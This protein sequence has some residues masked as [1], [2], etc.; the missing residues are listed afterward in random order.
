MDVNW[1]GLPLQQ[2]YCNQLQWSLSKPNSLWINFCVWYRQAT[3]IHRL[4]YQRFPI[5]ELYLKFCLYRILVYTD[6]FNCTGNPLLIEEITGILH[7]ALVT[8]NSLTK[9]LLNLNGGWILCRPS[10]MQNFQICVSLFNLRP[11]V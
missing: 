6:R 4:N 11:I 3:S 1:Q 2:F 8:I 10:N 5:L 9:S 7:Q